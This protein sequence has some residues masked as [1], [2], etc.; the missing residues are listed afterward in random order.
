M[1][2]V[3]NMLLYS[4]ELIK[5]KGLLVPILLNTDTLIRTKRSDL[6]YSTDHA[7][8]SPGIILFSALFLSSVIYV[9]HGVFVD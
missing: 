7:D 4:A 2:V 3:C 1:H 5:Q 9:S 8:L 6:E